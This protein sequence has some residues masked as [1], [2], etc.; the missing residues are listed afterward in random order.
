MADNVVALDVGEARIGV[1]RGEVGSS[2]AFGRGYI[3]RSNLKS[4]VAA[5]RERLV[6]ENAVRVVVGLPRRS[7]GGDSAQTK[8]VRDF[9]AALRAADLD[10]VFEDERYTTQLASRGL[11]TS[12]MSKK[13]RQEKG[14]LDEAAAVLILETYLR[15]T[16]PGLQRGCKG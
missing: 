3:V 8:A 10:V 6:A 2:F 9:A 11:I 14:L 4:D 7:D 13:K 5:V 12:G 1:A 15:K 16:A